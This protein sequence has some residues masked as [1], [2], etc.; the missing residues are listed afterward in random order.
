MW[1]GSLLT[2]LTAKA[3]VDS[4]TFQAFGKLRY[5]G[6][7]ELRCSKLN[8]NYAQ[9][10]LPR[11]KRNDSFHMESRI[12]G[13]SGGGP[14]LLAISARAGLWFRATLW[15]SLN[16]RAVHLKIASSLPSLESGL[17]CWSD[18]GSR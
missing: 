17:L 18:S 11:P 3:K 14:C 15:G 5:I 6:Q 4:W 1:L 12:S 8:L 16:L 2:S 7:F 9:L 13:P 10:P